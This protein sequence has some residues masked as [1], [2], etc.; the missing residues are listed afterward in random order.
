M[1]KYWVEWFYRWHLELQTKH[2][3]RNG[4]EVWRMEHNISLR[5][6]YR[7]QIDECE[8]VLLPYLVEQK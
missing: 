4:N 6:P 5:T 3:V 8:Q 7:L 2:E 1:T